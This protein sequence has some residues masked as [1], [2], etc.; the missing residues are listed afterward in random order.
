[1][2]LRKYFNG[3]KYKIIYSLFWWYIYIFFG[4]YGFKLLLEKIIFDEE[5]MFVRKERNNLKI[6]LI[7]SWRGVYIVGRS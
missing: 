7:K 3:E 2:V 1:M 6:G 5:D 4:F